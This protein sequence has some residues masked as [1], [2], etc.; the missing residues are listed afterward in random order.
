MPISNDLDSLITIICIFSAIYPQTTVKI[1]VT[2]QK[3]K[4]I[5]LVLR[6]VIDPNIIKP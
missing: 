2:R 5:I 6:V 1:T 3:N 4:K